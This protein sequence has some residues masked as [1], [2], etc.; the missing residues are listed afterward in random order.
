MKAVRAIIGKRLYDHLFFRRHYRRLLSR[1]GY[2]TGRVDGED[3]YHARWRRLTPLVE[4]YSYRLYSR[5][6]GPT[7]D[8]VPY[9]LLHNIIEPR[10][11]PRELW[12]EYEDKN[13][14]ARFVGDNILPQTVASRQ[15]G[16][17][18]SYNFD[19]STFNA[20]LLIKPSVDRSCG[21]GIVR[22]DRLGDSYRSADGT[23]LSDD[24][25]AAYGPD[26][27]LQEAVV[28]HPF[29]QHLC[30][31]A[32]C[33]MRLAVYR[34]VADG[35]AHV[36]AAVLRVGREGMIV[37]NIVAGGRFVR[38]NVSDGT[39]G[40]CFLGRFGERT[41]SWNGVDLSTQRLVV[42]AWD[43]VLALATRVADSLAPHHL[44]ALDIALTPQEKPIL[45]EY[46]IGGFS[47]YLF[48]FT[49]QTVFGPWTEEVVAYCRG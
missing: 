48:H 4:P 13:N 17:K 25:L 6:C 46:N 36:T 12:D 1:L 47:S 8:I 18:I 37:D 24:Y 49:G 33:T 29:M 16:G 30:S 43:K 32:V 14:F 3:A 10:L 11:N 26:F 39:L 31:T 20:P 38:V 44:L 45:I 23:I 28:Q 40:D 9:D 41:A 7:P 15:D 27:V 5:F 42:P 19:L 22:F 2:A 21:E 35:T 34:S